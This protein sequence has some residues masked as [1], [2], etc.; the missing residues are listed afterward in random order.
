MD[1]RR[2]LMIL[3]SVCVVEVMLPC[4]NDYLNTCIIMK[5]RLSLDHD[6]RV[7]WSIMAHHELMER[8]LDNACYRVS[9]TIPKSRRENL[10]Q[11]G[12]RPPTAAGWTQ[13]K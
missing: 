7:W 12:E 1:R 3:I 5:H 6:R 4:D 10:I 9:C 13:N 2:Q 11:S 8:S